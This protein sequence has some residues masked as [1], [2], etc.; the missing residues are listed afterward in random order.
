M[1][2]AKRQAARPPSQRTAPGRL[3]RLVGR[4]LFSTCFSRG[5]LEV[6]E[7]CLLAT[8]EAARKTQPDD[9]PSGFAVERCDGKE[10]ECGNCRTEEA[11]NCEC[12]IDGLQTRV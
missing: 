7:G 1:Q 3:Q 9:R 12:R 8:C 6:L 2:I 4:R 5:F 10:I 11:E